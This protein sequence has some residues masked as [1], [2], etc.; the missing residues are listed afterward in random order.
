MKKRRREPKKPTGRRF[1]VKVVTVNGDNV[2]LMIQD[3]HED[4]EKAEEAVK[5]IFAEALRLGG[6]MLVI[7][8]RV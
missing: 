1:V 3:T 5:E 8:H 6:T 2:N 7:P 4:R